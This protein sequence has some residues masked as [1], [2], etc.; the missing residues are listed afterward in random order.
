MS[1]PELWSRKNCSSCPVRWLACAPTV[2]L[3][4]SLIGA[5]ERFAALAYERSTSTSPVVAAKTFS[6][7]STTNWF[8]ALRFKRVHEILLAV[9]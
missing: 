4:P 1:L 8:S 7:P 5:P 9:C 3:P 6:S 2:P